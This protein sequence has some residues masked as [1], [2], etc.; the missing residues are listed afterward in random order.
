[1][2]QEG[3]KKEEGEQ[4]AKEDVKEREEGTAASAQRKQDS[5]P[6]NDGRE[7][8]NLPGEG[9]GE[10]GIATSDEPQLRPQTS[11]GQRTQ[12]G[13]D[14]LSVSQLVEARP[15]TSVTLSPSPSKGRGGRPSA[16]EKSKAKMQQAYGIRPL[17]SCPSPPPAGVDCGRGETEDR[18]QHQEFDGLEVTKRDVLPGQAQR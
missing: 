16:L 12:G 13:E 4:A 2:E 1:M 15:T 5:E 10:V 11:A 3:T 17:F 7:A 6:Q 14:K 18:L 8:L 9:H